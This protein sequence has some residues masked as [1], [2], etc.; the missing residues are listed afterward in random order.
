MRR[1][2]ID[3]RSLLAPTYNQHI[4]NGQQS[5]GTAMEPIAV[6]QTGAVYAL[7]DDAAGDGRQHEQQQELPAKVAQGRDA[8]ATESQEVQ[9]GQVRQKAGL[10]EDAGEVLALVGK[11]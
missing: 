1:S 5:L 2:R 4:G 7:A 9:E 10:E 8:I 3:T 6:G 11:R